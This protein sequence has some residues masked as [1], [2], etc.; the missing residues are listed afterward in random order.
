VR[1]AIVHRLAP[2]RGAD[3]RYRLENEFH[4]LIARA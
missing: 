2:F 4:T 1:N 3:G